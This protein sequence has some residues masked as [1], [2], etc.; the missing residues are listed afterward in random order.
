M[1]GVTRVGCF[2]REK[3]QRRDMSQ[4]LSIHFRSWR[5]LRAQITFAHFA[6]FAA[7][8]AP[9]ITYNRLCVE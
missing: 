2:C 6:P 7:K 1:Y 3:R 9:T 8:A 4:L 5:Y